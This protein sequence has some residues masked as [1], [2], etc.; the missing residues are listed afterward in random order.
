MHEREMEA[1]ASELESTNRGV[2]ALYAELD[3]QAVQLRSASEL[4]S[5]FLSNVSHE[6][7]TPLNSIL[8]IARLLL[9]RIDGELT[10]EQ[11]RQVEYILASARSLSELI[12]DLL[13]IAK[14]EAGKVEVRTAPIA[15]SALLATL[16]GVLRPLRGSGA[17]DLV[18][19]SGEGLPLL[20][21]DEGKVSQILRNLV[22][23]ALKFTE[24]GEVRVAVRHDPAPDRLLFAVSDTGIGIAP[25]DGERVFQEF[26]QIEHRLQARVRGTGLGLP[27]S[28]HL[29]RLLGGE[30]ELESAP[31]HGSTFTLSLPTG[32]PAISTGMPGETSVL[33]I[34]DDPMARYVLRHALGEGDIAVVE[35]E[36]GAAGLAAARAV[37]PAIIF[38]DLRMPG[39][40]GFDVL[41]CLAADPGTADIP[42][43]VLTSS[44][45][46]AAE[47]RRLVHARAILSKSE[48]GRE[49]IRALLSKLV[50]E[51]CNL[52]DVAS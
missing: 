12:D 21:S 9:D 39:L 38:L 51:S 50:P 45:L 41:E 48:V 42:V 34:D 26:V 20:H 47:R 36:D 4:K 27:L 5:R 1:L 3:D 22:S 30:L 31:G 24:A 33:V 29:A 35:A 15:V 7:R 23:N 8:A 18:F 11:E 6:F 16:R 46:G 28:R 17:V 32:R 19:E 25:A 52:S 10:G 13:D 49:R 43:V 37:H 44:D 40:S 2:V 14:V